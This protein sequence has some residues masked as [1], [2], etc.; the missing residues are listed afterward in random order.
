M[1]LFGRDR[2]SYYNTKKY[3]NNRMD[4]EKKYRETFENYKVLLNK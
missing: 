2:T 4:T 1:Y 3:H